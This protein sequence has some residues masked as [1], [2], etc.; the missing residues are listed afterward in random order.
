MTDKAA[1]DP[2]LQAALSEEEQDPKPSFLFRHLSEIILVILVGCMLAALTYPMSVFTIPAGHVGVLFSRFGGGTV[3][4]SVHEEGI[5]LKWPWDRIYLYD[6]RLQLM[7]ARYDVLSRDGLLLDVEIAIRFH[8]EKQ[9]APHLHQKIGQDYR[10]ILLNSEIGS[11]I[12]AVLAQY[13]TEQIYAL[14][15]ARLEEM[16]EENSS[17]DVE[18]GKNIFKNDHKE[19]TLEEDQKL[20]HID[21]IR[22]K[23]I[24]LPGLIT[25]AIE[26]K[27]EQQQVAEEF[28]YRIEREKLEAQR[29]RIEAEGIR[30]FQNIIKKGISQ[31]LLHWKGIEAS[32]KLAESQNGK[33]IIF[34]SSETGLP[35]ILGD[36]ETNKLTV[37]PPEIDPTETLNLGE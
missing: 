7:T 34:G 18:R 11:K 9:F 10:N 30:D 21:D 8:I 35:I 23:S 26:K 31:E 19:R 28:N 27:K 4:D 1:H 36:M 15:R 5:Q 2:I 20:L 29:K 14:D 17:H 32:L 24:K 25:E 22:I 16:I 13:K 33:I 37:P 12:R 3:T 6:S